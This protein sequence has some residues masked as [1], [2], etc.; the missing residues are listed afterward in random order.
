MLVIAKP[1]A[2]MM[3]A[4]SSVKAKKLQADYV[5]YS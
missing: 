4:Y 1:V 3:S 2:Q 5:G